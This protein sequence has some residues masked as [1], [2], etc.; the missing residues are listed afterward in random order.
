MNR[1]HEPFAWPA[2]LFRRNLWRF[3][4]LVSMAVF[5]SLSADECG[6]STRNQEPEE[7]L[8]EAR[9]TKVS[10][11]DKKV[12]DI[13]KNE[14][15]LTRQLRRL[16]P[17]ALLVLGV[18]A[19][20]F[21]F[22]SIIF[23]HSNWGQSVLHPEV[24][25]LATVELSTEALP[26]G[27]DRV[28]LELLRTKNK[29]H[30]VIES[31]SATRADREFARQI[32]ERT[33]RQLEA[34]LREPVDKIVGNGQPADI[35]LFPFQVALVLTGFPPQSGL[36]CGGTLI[37]PQW[38]LTAAHCV[39]SF[40]KPGDLSVFLGSAS[41]SDRNALPLKT[42]AEGGMIP[43]SD[44]NPGSGENDV[45]LLHL[46][47]P[48]Q[49]WQPIDLVQPGDEADMLASSGIATVS[50]WGATQEGG[51]ISERLLWAP[52]PVVKNDVCIEKYKHAPRG[53][54]KNILNGM[55]CAG[56]GEG[57]SCQGDS[58]GPLTM[59]MRNGA[60]LLEGVV[61]WGEGCARRISP[62]KPD[63]YPGVYTRVPT[64]WK[65]IRQ[66]MAGDCKVEGTQVA[67]SGAK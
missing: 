61:S 53:H 55:L 8:R 10:D 3:H 22:W 32:E 33:S 1:S 11:T 15:L 31:E 16:H 25:Q 63:V 13:D 18:A 37:D 51:A 43:R 66:C 49:G 36:R 38:V 39:P 46:S 44:Y 54:R 64:Y 59:R 5:I 28:A 56:T 60:Q 62:D 9:R 20:T 48:V 23:I 12:P 47:A 2:E 26:E 42:I 19:G 57:D 7:A 65:W 40:M 21:S 24:K 52:V 35:K 67:T 45:A 29:A 17:F 6:K 34:Q 41:L 58:G 50:G 27:T 30:S 4:V 14:Y